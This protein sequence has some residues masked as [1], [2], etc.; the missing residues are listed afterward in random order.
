[1]KPFKILKLDHDFDYSSDV[2]KTKVHLGEFCVAI[3]TF[4]YEKHQITVDA[5]D[6]IAMTDAVNAEEMSNAQELLGLVI[7]HQGHDAMMNCP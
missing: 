2:F 1:M 3:V 4:T 5:P 6:A 7:A